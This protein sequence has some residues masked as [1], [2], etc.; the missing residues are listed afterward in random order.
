MGDPTVKSDVDLSIFNAEERQ[1]SPSV[2]QVAGD[3]GWGAVV[4]YCYLSNK[5]FPTPEILEKL[6]E[7]LPHLIKTYPSMQSRQVELISKLASVDANLIAA[8]NGGSELILILGR[9]YGKR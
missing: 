6:K 9:G 3:R 5:F 7:Q 4:D 8:G 1:H 2:G